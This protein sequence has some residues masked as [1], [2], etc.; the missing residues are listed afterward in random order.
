M[1]L[2]NPSQVQMSTPPTSASNVQI[3]APLVAYRISLGCGETRTMAVQELLW[4]V[5]LR[6][7]GPN[8]AVVG[9]ILIQLI[10]NWKV[11][12]RASFFLL[13][14]MDVKEPISTTMEVVNHPIADV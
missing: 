13:E 9:K 11:L 10:I 8:L 12:F 7:V 14:F 5:R 1:A 4:L 6:Q 2:Q 3:R